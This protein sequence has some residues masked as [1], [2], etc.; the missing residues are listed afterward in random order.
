MDKQSGMPSERIREVNKIISQ[1]QHGSIAIKTGAPDIDDVRREIDALHQRIEAHADTFLPIIQRLVSVEA[2]INQLEAMRVKAWHERN[3]E[4]CRSD[5]SPT[6]E[7]P[8]YE[9]C[10]HGRTIC[11]KC[12]AKAPKPECLHSNALNADYC[13]KCGLLRDLWEKP[14]PVPAKKLEHPLRRKADTEAAI[15]EILFQ[16]GKWACRKVDA[17]DS[18]RISVFDRITQDTKKIMDLL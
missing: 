15:R 16:H 2:S 14:V 4:A 13:Y 7:A 18:G 3:D 9:R 6:Q 10:K 12:H 17:Y 8:N 1:D 5:K 11:P